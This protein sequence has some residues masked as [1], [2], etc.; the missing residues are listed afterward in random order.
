MELTDPSLGWDADN[1]GLQRDPSCSRTHSWSIACPVLSRC[2]WPSV[3]VHARPLSAH[4]Q[5]GA[6]LAG[7]VKPGL[8]SHRGQ[9]AE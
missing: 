7:K 8:L 4:L 3:L 2:C 5:P 9:E 6:L 1:G